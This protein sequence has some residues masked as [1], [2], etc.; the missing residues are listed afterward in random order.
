MKFKKILALAIGLSMSAMMAFGSMAAPIVSAE[1]H[2]H[3]V[4]ITARR[5]ATP[6]SNWKALNDRALLSGIVRAI[7]PPTTKANRDNQNWSHTSNYAYTKNYYPA[8]TSI[9]VT[10]GGS[11]DVCLYTPSGEYI[12]DFSGEQTGNHYQTTIGPGEEYYAK[13]VNT[14]GSAS[15]NATYVVE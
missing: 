14:S 4:G 7:N 6:P 15:T 12:I 1:T 10:A 5:L 11:F 9:T 8:D 2:A 3:A 13:I